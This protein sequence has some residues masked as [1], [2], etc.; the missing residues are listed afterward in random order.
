MKPY[1]L[2]SSLALLPLAIAHGH[3][4]E[5]AELELTRGQFAHLDNAAGWTPLIGSGIRGEGRVVIETVDFAFAGGRNV[6]YFSDLQDGFGDNKLE[7]CVVFDPTQ[8]LR[9]ELAVRT[10]AASNDLRI[11][12]N[13]NFYSSVADCNADLAADDNGRR[14]SG[15]NNNE[16][17]DFQ[18]GAAEIE[19][20][21]WTQLEDG[22]AAGA[23]PQ[24]ASVVRLSLRARDRKGDNDIVYFGQVKLTNGDQL[25]PLAGSNFAF[26]QDEVVTC[27]VPGCNDGLL[28]PASLGFGLEMTAGEKRLFQGENLRWQANTDALDDDRSVD[29]F[30]Q[31]EQLVIDSDSNYLSGEITAASA[32]MALVY[33][34]DRRLQASFDDEGALFEL[35]SRT[36]DTWEPASQ[37]LYD[38]SASSLSNQARVEIDATR[39]DVIDTITDRLFY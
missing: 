32:A 29:V 5:A 9:F 14:L 1:L 11:R 25:L 36:A 18:L 17:F 7:Q 10:T 34:S 38:S 6:M 19:A 26:Y 4:A 39:I 16:D 3:A 31:A 21:E 12:V 27:Y 35:E 2:A 30:G 8:D 33:A 24:D 20:N 22:F 28:Q 13:P 23:F 37:R 15:T